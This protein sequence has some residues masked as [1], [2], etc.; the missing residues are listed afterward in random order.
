MVAPPTPASH[1]TT[2]ELLKS[3]IGPAALDET[4]SGR[5]H[6]YLVNADDPHD[7][8]DR[9]TADIN[10]ILTHVESA[11]WKQA[12][13]RV[14]TPAPGE[15]LSDVVA[16]IRV[17]LW[18]RSL[19]RYDAWRGAPLFSFI[20]TCIANACATERRR[21]ARLA[22]RAS[23][24]TV[25]PET[26]DRLRELPD[27]AAE[28][29]RAIRFAE[30]LIANPSDSAFGLTRCQARVIQ[31]VLAADPGEP[32]CEIAR[33]LGYERAASFSQMLLRIR[34]RILESFENESNLD[35]ATTTTATGKGGD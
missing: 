15:T 3:D 18:R 22:R 30:R 7:L 16:R 10:T 14:H 8:A 29:A 27:L 32:Q 11:I 9:I 2:P 19:P 6:P 28:Q 23:F 21:A 31:A 35:H 34:E 24:M 5:Q 20:W 17:H 33:R 12:R 26:L 1:P 25:E 13:V 4:R